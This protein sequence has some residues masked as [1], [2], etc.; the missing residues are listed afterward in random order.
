M[1]P[2]VGAGAARWTGGTLRCLWCL[3][4]AGVHVS[5]CVVRG[6]L[7]VGVGAR[8]GTCPQFPVSSVVVVGCVVCVC[9]VWC[10]IL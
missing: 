5:I 2:V 3:G 1:Y 10:Y 4:L 6:P 7:A 9:G 8:R